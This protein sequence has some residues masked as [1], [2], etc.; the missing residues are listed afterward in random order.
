M[1]AHASSYAVFIAIA[2]L[3]YW[4]NLKTKRIKRSFILLIF[5]AFGFF[6][7]GGVYKERI[8]PLVNREITILQG[9]ADIAG[10]A[11]GRGR[12]WIPRVGLFFDLPVMSTL[13]GAP[14]SGREEN[15]IL[16]WGNPHNDYLRILFMTGIIGFAFYLLVLIRIYF[17]GNRL[18]ISERFLVNGSLLV[19]I[20]YSIVANTMIYNCLLYIILAIFAYACLPL[21]KKNYSR[22]P[23]V[24]H[25]PAHTL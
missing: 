15:S 4:Y 8:S 13:F 22:F 2:A 3:F 24:I 16:W 5:A 12:R 7:S 6:F 21:S 14:T 20:L 11:H 19:V 18:P 1:V 17:A 25:K 23:S 10:I 9:E